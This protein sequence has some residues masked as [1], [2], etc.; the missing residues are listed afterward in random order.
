[1]V[2]T[3]YGSEAVYSDL[4]RLETVGD[5]EGTGANI[6]SDSSNSN[7]DVEVGPWTQPSFRSLNTRQPKALWKATVERANIERYTGFTLW[8]MKVSIVTTCSHTMPLRS[9][10][11]Q[12]K[13]SENSGQQ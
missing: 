1:M 13:L 10:L 11:C 12:N 4:L 9:Q 6:A 8:I 5:T 2:I 3:S 7:N